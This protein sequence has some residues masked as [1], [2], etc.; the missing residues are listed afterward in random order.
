M[1]SLN[2]LFCYMWFLQSYGI[3]KIIKFFKYPSYTRINNTH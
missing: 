1:P 2:K 3:S